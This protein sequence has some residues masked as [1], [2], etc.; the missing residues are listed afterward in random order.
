M[1]KEAPSKAESLAKLREYAKWSAQR[2]HLVCEAKLQGASYTEIMDA[3]GLAKA[4]VNAILK[5]A[6]IAKE[7]GTMT[8][9]QVE[10]DAERFRN[11]GLTANDLRDEAIIQRSKEDTRLA[12]MLDNIAS[13]MDTLD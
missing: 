11:R 10:L 13:V 8:K 7:S 6:G 2:D 3:S 9:S 1:S 12:D 5:K 4:T